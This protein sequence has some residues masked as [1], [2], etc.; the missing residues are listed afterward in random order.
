MGKRGT[1]TLVAQ[2]RQ[3]A[4]EAYRRQGYIVLDVKE[5]AGRWQ[6]G[7]MTGR[8]Q[9]PDCAKSRFYRQGAL[10]IEAGLPLSE[11][12]DLLE[13]DKGGGSIRHD[14]STG[15]SLAEAM[16]NQGKRFDSGEIALIEAGEHSGRLE[17]A[18]DRLAGDWEEREKMRKSFQL[19][20]LYP[21]FL[22][23]ISFGALLFIIFFVLPAIF[24]VFRDLALELPWPTQ[25]LMAVGNIPPMYL[26]VLG[27]V[28]VALGLLAAV[29][30]GDQRLGTKIDG[31]LL[32]VPVWGALW[33]T[34]DM[35][36]FLGGL[37]TML[38]GGIVIDGAVINAAAACGNRYLARQ[39]EEVGHRLSRGSSFVE[40]ME[41][42]GISPLL[43]RLIAAGEQSGELPR[44]LSHGS[45]YCREETGS[46]LRTIQTMAEPA[47]IL[48]MGLVA[49]FLAISIIL[50]MLDVMSA[51]M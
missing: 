43:K 22:L 11:V 46:R 31:L 30:Y 51:Y 29:A 41:D 40:G 4:Y 27:A 42:I 36:L 15:M 39:L 14:L 3:A 13:P 32:K 35:G 10:L 25:V 50:P 37:S 5:A 47:L 20:M 45:R 38:E 21:L 9:Q 7:K 23:V 17:W 8:W 12:M 2:N 48:L 33:Q 16:R 49:G 26:V 19:S 6:L 18:F 34:K 44:M 24:S 28:V 1:A